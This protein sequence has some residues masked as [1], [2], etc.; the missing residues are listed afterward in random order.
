[1]KKLLTTHTVRLLLAFL[2]IVGSFTLAKADTWTV[3]G[4]LTSVFGTTWDP[5]NTA[6]DMTLSG[7]VWT[8]TSGTFTYSTDNKPAFKVCKDHRW[9]TAYPSD[10]YEVNYASF[11]GKTCTL[12]VTFNSTSKAVNATLTETTPTYLT[13][14]TV[15]L[16][17]DGVN[18]SID[19]ILKLT[20]KGNGVF[21]T[22]V[23]NANTSWF[24]LTIFPTSNATIS[25]WDGSSG[26]NA[27]LYGKGS[28]SLGD[29]TIDNSQTDN[30]YL[31]EAGDYTITVS[32]ITT[33]NCKITL[34]KKTTPV[35]HT[36]SIA[37]NDAEVFGASWSTSETSTEMT[38]TASGSGIYTWTK[39]NVVYPENNLEF[40]IIE[41][42]TT[43]K[44]PSDNYVIT[45]LL[46]NNTYN[47]TITYDANTDAV[48]HSYTLVSAATE[49]YYLVGD[50]NSWAQLDA[51][52]AFTNNNGTWTLATTNFSGEF[53]IID[54]NLQ[55]YTS[56]DTFTKNNSTNVTV[57]TSG[58]NM[59]IADAGNYTFTLNV[60]ASS[61]SLTITGW[62]ADPLY[63]RHWTDNIANGSAV[64]MTTSDG[65]NYTVSNVTLA[66]G[67]YV[68]FS[69]VGS[70]A[71][72]SGTR[73]SYNGSNDKTFASGTQETA[74]AGGAKCYITPVAGKWNFTFNLSTGKWTPT[75]AEATAQTWYLKGDLTDWTSTSGTAMSTSDNITFTTTVNITSRTTSVS[76]VILIDGVGSWDDVNANHRYW[77]GGTTVTPSPSGATTNISKTTGSNDN[78]VLPKGL[79]GTYTFSFNSSTSKLTITGPAPVEVKDWYLL[80]KFDTGSW[81]LNNS[82][83]KFTYDE[84]TGNYVLRKTIS[85]N[86]NTNF[87]LSQ[88]VASGAE[89]WSEINGSRYNPASNTQASLNTELSFGQH[90]DGAWTL[91]WGYI[92]TYTFTINA[93]GN[94][95]TITGPARADRNT[96]KMYIIGNANAGVWQ[97]NH[98][99]EMTETATGSGIFV[100]EN[101][102]L[103]SGSDFSFTSKLGIKDDDWKTVNLYRWYAVSDNTFEVTDNMV[104]NYAATP[105]TNGDE[106]SLKDTGDGT[107]N[108]TGNKNNFKMKTSGSYRITVNTNNKTVMFQQMYLDLY[109]FG[110]GFHWGNQT[111]NAWDP[112]SAI[113]MTT[114]DGKIYHLDAVTFDEGDAVGFIFSTVRADNNDNGGK[115]YVA[116]N[117]F[118][119]SNSDNYAIRY[120]ETQNDINEKLTMVAGSTNDAE[121]LTNFDQHRWFI[122]GEV[123]RSGKYNVVVDLENM[124]VML[125]ENININ[126]EMYIRLEQTSNVT[127]PGIRVWINDGALTKFEGD[128]A[129]G[130]EG[131]H[132]NEGNTNAG[133][134]ESQGKTYYLDGKTWFK[135]REYTSYDNRKWWEWE[136]GGDAFRIASITFYRNGNKNDNPADP[137]GDL[138]R[139]SG[140]LYYT[141]P[142]ENDIEDHTSEYYIDHVKEA[143]ECATMIDDHYYV[144]FVNTPG[145][146]TVYC[147]AW[148]SNKNPLISAFPGSQCMV[149]GYTDDGFAVYRYDFGLKSYWQNQ[150]VAGI[151]FNSGPKE[152]QPNE[153][154]QQTGDFPFKNGGVFDYVGR[155]SLGRSLGT[156]IAKGVVN[157]P[158]YEVEDELT[159]VYY[160]PYE[161][162]SYTV[163]IYEDGEQVGTTTTEYTGA[164][165]AKD[166]NTANRKSLNTEGK[167]D[168]VFDVTHFTAEKDWI[169]SNGKTHLAGSKG[170]LLMQGKVH[171]DQSNW[172]KLVR[173]NDYAS[174]S[175]NANWN[176]ATLVGKKIAG[177]NLGGQLV[178]NLNPTMIVETLPANALS[179][180]SY[181]KNEYIMPHFNDNYTVNG[182]GKD[183]CDFFFVR[184]KANEVATITWAVYTGKDNDGNY[185]F[186]V[187]RTVVPLAENQNFANGMFVHGNNYGLQGAINVKSWDLATVKE[188][189]E[190]Q[191]NPNM[192]DDKVLTPGEAYTFD[193]IIRYKETPTGGSSGAP[194]IN[195]LKEVQVNSDFNPDDSQF[196][197]Y[198]IDI[199]VKKGIVTAIKDVKND[200]AK[201]I[202]SVKVYDTM[203]VERREMQGGINIVV[204]T[205][206]DGTRSVQKI[207][208]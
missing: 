152:G 38:E 69:T 7:N 44:A 3:A 115:Q 26:F 128:W 198:P 39:N 24:K 155:V 8:W 202:K 31:P 165:Y 86:K 163:P 121:A 173:A 200:A 105:Q 40:K 19:N 71:W 126:E 176:A 93:A 36:Y 113:Q 84:E 123:A 188:N 18:R 17:G 119:P 97:A 172:V 207:L 179:A 127:N 63:L 122:W 195:R 59:S 101:V 4:N 190:V 150:D 16:V 87:I 156:I 112:T 180:A 70:G 77:N 78:I 153:A 22:D 20:D 183:D 146:S 43:Y 42:H 196:E 129:D 148:D 145:W 81:Q 21:S 197:I 151:V 45:D 6:N 134:V 187:P 14:C 106:L 94:K 50:M 191:S 66:K 175:T 35:T 171:Y 103:M 65:V 118:F 204:T 192:D 147:Y 79:K 206:S 53:K 25:G 11:N 164:F 208:K 140:V 52:Y 95:L 203:G 184:P 55:Y 74:S 178:D 75:L 116:K 15:A 131:T 125:K 92:G 186:Y 96:G 10:N 110:K 27:H 117:G 60:G 160:D 139:R 182:G 30:L 170:E 29:N 23:T 189:G 107:D 41:D 199:D 138:N 130:A 47:L 185:Q 201:T 32:E 144:Y 169:D 99:V 85:T 157:G 100:A 34:T 88:K 181:S 12:T 120:D 114:T 54:Q 98:G 159:I 46:P 80:S 109:M 67:E 149:V 142:P 124:T 143:P 136:V 83:D 168:Y 76:N 174:N 108:G 1:M 154:D 141:W 13:N 90:D 132:M 49:A 56:G 5:S 73:Y 193:A 158:L 58:N 205:Y 61:K 51:N 137:N 33:S 133:N 37:G 48:S 166:N 9:G 167:R 102:Q 91:P 111:P 2:C 57:T 64:A 72:E 177:D 194:A 82:S 161:S 89:N 104:G 162:G 28:L 135:C 62:P 68:V